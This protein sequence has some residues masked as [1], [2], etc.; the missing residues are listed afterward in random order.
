MLRIIHLHNAGGEV[1]LFFFTSFF[2]GRGGPAGPF[3]RRE[4]NRDT[5]SS[6][7]DTT[8]LLASSILGTIL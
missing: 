1:P 3:T 7:L 8:A 6:L 5:H 2:L 4:N